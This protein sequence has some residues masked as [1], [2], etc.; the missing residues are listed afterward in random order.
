MKFTLRRPCANCPFRTDCRQ[1][2]LGRKRATEIATSITAHQKTFSCHKTNDFSSG[3][4][5]ET[6]N[7]QHCAGALVLLEK[8][9]Q[10][11]QMMRIAERLGFYDRHKLDMAAPVFDSTKD[12]IKHHAAPARRE[13]AASAP[14]T[15]QKGGAS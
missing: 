15:T 7:S 10:P 9:N 1:G 4:V 13:K 5:E 3:E 12:F 2:W 11:N 6:E 8:R 14:T